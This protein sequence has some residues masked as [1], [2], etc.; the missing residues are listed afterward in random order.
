MAALKNWIVIPFK[1]NLATPLWERKC[2]RYLT[3][4]TTLPFPSFPL[5]FPV[6]H[7]SG[8]TRGSTERI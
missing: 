6:F 2:E 3:L 5:F 4:N 7:Y 8:S 1:Q